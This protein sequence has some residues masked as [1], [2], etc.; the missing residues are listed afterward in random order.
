MF[1]LLVLVGLNFT[2]ILIDFSKATAFFQCDDAEIQTTE[3]SVSQTM[4]DIVA[5]D[6]RRWTRARRRSF[7]CPPYLLHRLIIVHEAFSVVHDFI[8]GS[9]WK[10]SGPRELIFLRR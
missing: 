2:P 10:K 9:R 8:A 6:C 7:A 1:P 3:L 4:V 5:Q